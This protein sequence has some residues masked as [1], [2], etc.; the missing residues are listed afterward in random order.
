MHA[1]PVA[2]RAT[3]VREVSSQRSPSLHVAASRSLPGTQRDPIEPSPSDSQ[4]FIALHSRCA[5]G[6]HSGAV[7]PFALHMP[8][9]V[10]RTITDGATQVRVVVPGVRAQVVPATQASSVVQG[11]PAATG[12]RHMPA[13]HARLVMHETRFA[14]V[15]AMTPQR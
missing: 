3:Q 8:P 5:R 11:A 14:G 12:R 1:W 2:A 6:L 13:M 15:P 10:L 4:E 9:V 7:A